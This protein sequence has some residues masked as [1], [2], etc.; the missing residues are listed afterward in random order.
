MRLK[1]ITLIVPLLFCIEHVYAE[2]KGDHY[3]NHVSSLQFSDSKHICGKELKRFTVSLKNAGSKNKPSFNGAEI[4]IRDNKGNMVTRQKLRSLGLNHD[5]KIYACIS[6]DYIDNT[7][8]KF[9][10]REDKQSTS[11][12]NGTSTRALKSSALIE[13]CDLNSLIRGI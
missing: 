7:Y 1:I 11:Y 10:F 4:F 6:E 2:C 5:D 8:V 13:Q 3:K 9:Y 12:S